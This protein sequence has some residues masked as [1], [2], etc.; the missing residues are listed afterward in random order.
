MISKRDR[1]RPHYEQL[2]VSAILQ[3][4]ENLINNANKIISKQSKIWTDIA[5]QLNNVISENALYTLTVKKL[6]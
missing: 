2:I 5:G 1:S 3:H 4:K 6:F